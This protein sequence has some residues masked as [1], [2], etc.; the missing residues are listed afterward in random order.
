MSRTLFGLRVSPWTERARWALDHHQLSYDYHEHV[1]ML[2]ELL[3][4]RKARTSKASVPLLADGDDVVMGSL[5]IAKHAERRRS[6]PPL[7]P[8]GKE[9]IVDRWAEV[10][11]VISKAGRDRLLA[12][13]AADPKAQAESLPSFVPGGLRGLM[14]PTAGMAVRFLARKYGSGSDPATVEARAEATIRP[15]LE[16][17]REAIKDGGYVLAKDCFTFADIALASALQVLRPR[18]EMAIG[19]ATRDAWT[20]EK[21]ADEFEDLVAWRDTVYAKHRAS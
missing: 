15:L 21:L 20:N 6:G 12:R 18:A 11:E 17:T 16:E 19:A 4:R 7:F 2:G 3:L 8:D 14:A 9:E 13:M 5:A 10:A 1:P